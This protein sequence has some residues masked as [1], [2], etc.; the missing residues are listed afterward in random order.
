M[1]RRGVITPRMRRC[2]AILSVGSLALAGAAPVAAAVHSAETPSMSATTT[3]TVAVLIQEAM[4]GLDH[5]WDVT[6]T[7]DNTMLVTERDRERITARFPN[8]TEEVLAENTPGVWH[9]GETGLMG[10]VV[11]PGFK[12]NSAFY[13]CHGSDAGRGLDIRVVR[14]KVNDA[15]T[16]ATQVKTI[17]KG[18]PVSTGRHGGCRLRF[19]PDGAL[20]IATGDAAIGTN[21]QDLSSLGGKVLRVDP[22]T[23]EAWPGNPFAGTS[24]PQTRLV[25]TFGHRNVQG[26]AYRNAADADKGMWSVEHGPDRDDEVNQLVVGGNA[27]WNPVPGYDESVPM[28]DLSLGD[29]V[30]EARWSSGTPTLATSGATWL[31]N[32]RWGTWKGRLAV[33][34]LNDTSLQLMRFSAAGRLLSQTDIP[35]LDDNFGR[36]R[37]AQTGPQGALYVTTDNGDGNDVV[38]KV[39]PRE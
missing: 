34:A 4:A 5:P 21:P 23:G 31:T 25:Y 7:P 38:L 22:D 15:F 11:D 27:G 14:W 18:M 1:D 2:A 33:A 13:T 28:T 24:D 35:D 6:F 10:I 9:G 29:N 20:Y 26:L 36:L 30:F 8:G 16:T 3:P 39:T 12:R 17:V 37:T 32:D 19:A